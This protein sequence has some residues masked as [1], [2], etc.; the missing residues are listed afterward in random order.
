[1]AI[2]KNS[3]IMLIRIFYKNAA[4]RNHGDWVTLARLF[5]SNMKRQILK[6]NVELNVRE[7]KMIAVC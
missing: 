3:L 4:F 1:M 7:N 6:K 5:L 2:D